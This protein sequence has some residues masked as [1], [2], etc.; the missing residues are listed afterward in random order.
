MPRPPLSAFDAVPL[1]RPY[2]IGSR[3][4]RAGRTAGVF[5]AAEAPETA[6]AEMAFYRLLFFAESPL[7][8]WPVN[9]SEYTAFSAAVRT[10]RLLDLTLA[11]ARRRQHPMARSGRVRPLPGARRRGARGEAEALR[12]ESVRDPEGRAAVAVLTCAA[13]AKPEP[14]ERQTWKIGLGA[15]GAHA[16]CEFPP[17]R[18]EFDREAFASDPRLDGMVWSR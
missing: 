16:I 8:P 18:L 12:Y 1:R 17:A 9:P 3:F 10:E 6:V 7:T 14:L 4:R 15:T 2:P 5:Y 13:F 11:A